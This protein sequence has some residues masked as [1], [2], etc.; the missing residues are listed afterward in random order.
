VAH[1][2]IVRRVLIPVV[3]VTAWLAALSVKPAIAAADGILLPGTILAQEPTTWVALTPVVLALTALGLYGLWKMSGDSRR[4]ESV[5][6][7]DATE[8]ESVS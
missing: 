6:E 1:L 2:A 7:C 5:P 8:G 4:M 3:P